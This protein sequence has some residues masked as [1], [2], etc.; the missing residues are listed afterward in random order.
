M[1]RTIFETSDPTVKKAWEER[2]YRD[3]VKE[4][5]F[6]RFMSSGPDSIVQV[7]TDLEKDSGDA[8]TFTLRK[9]LAGAG[10]SGRQ[11]LKGNE[12]K[13]VTYTFDVALE[14]YRHGVID[15]GALDRQ[16]SLFSISKEAESALKDWASEKI[17]SLCFS[18]LQSSP[19]KVAYIYTSSGSKLGV[20]TAATAKAALTTADVITPGLIS[21]AKTWAQTGGN[22]TT[23]PLR[24]VKVEGKNYYVL[25][26]HPDVKYDLQNNST[27]TQALR[28][29]EVRGRDNPLFQGSIAIWDGVV[30]H[31]SEN[32]A[33]ATDGG[34]STVPWASCVLVGAQALG[35]AW[36]KRPTV[37]SDTEDYGNE[38]GKAINFI[39]GVE[40]PVFNSLDY[41]S[42]GIYCART[43]VSDA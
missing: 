2:L 17:D 10:V 31:E 28:E 40:K 38:E 6:S 8:V 14:L 20:S 30:V 13:L 27:F 22:R 19:T 29:A 25:L 34:G 42:L 43:K 33:T 36:G 15:G 23:V 35:F 41:G 4:S 39:C 26:V 12:E 24:P 3:A 9:K 21:Y 1:A 32:I 5:Y 16:R 11:K 7:Q 18:A 37:V